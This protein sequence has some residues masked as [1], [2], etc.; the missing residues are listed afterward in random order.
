ML[1]RAIAATANDGS[2][3]VAGMNYHISTDGVIDHTRSVYLFIV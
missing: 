3:C 1:Y 2:V